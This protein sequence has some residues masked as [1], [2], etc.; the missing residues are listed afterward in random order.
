MTDNFT[1]GL[2]CPRCGGTIQVPE[3]VAIVI[4]PFCELRSVVRGHR[5][6]RRY[7][8]SCRVDRGQAAAAFQKFL[9]SSMAIARDAPRQAQLTE[10]F[11]A[12]L[13]F[14]AAWGR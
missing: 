2:T 5:G 1:S 7:Q 13:P 12:Y 3:G 9:S 14:W 11:I 8:L 4:C 10:A 6:L